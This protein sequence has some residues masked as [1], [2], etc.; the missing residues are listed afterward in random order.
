MQQRL[1]RRVAAV[2]MVQ[3]TATAGSKQ[4]GK[5]DAMH[6]MNDRH[7]LKSSIACMEQM[8]PDKAKK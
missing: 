4:A 7:W 3:V 6:G 1:S 8:F 5:E 2:V